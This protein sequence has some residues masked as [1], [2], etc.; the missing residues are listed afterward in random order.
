MMA[1][2]TEDSPVE[3]QSGEPTETAEACEACEPVEA[4]EPCV[5]E[6]V[7]EPVETIEDIDIEIELAPPPKK[8]G[9]SVVSVIAWLVVVVAVLAGLA[10]AYT[11]FMGKEKE[12][13]S[14]ERQARIE[15]Y[16]NQVRGAARDVA[17]A[18]VLVNQGDIGSALAKLDSASEQ[19][20]RIAGDAATQ[21]DTEYGLRVQARKT[22]LV[23]AAEAIR[24][25]L[26]EVKDFTVA[27]V[28]KAREAMPEV[29][30][31][32]PKEEPAA[33]APPAEAAPPPAATPAPA[34]A[35][36]PAAPEAPP[37]VP[38]PPAVAAPPADATPPAAVQPPANGA[39]PTVAA[40]PAAAAPG[41]A[42]AA[43]PARHRRMFHRAPA[44]PPPTG[45]EG[46][47]GG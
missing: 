45:G 4:C 32:A 15:S 26:G 20:S 10:Y 24:Q 11:F 16:D 31:P 2:Q 22:A 19:L 35:P 42:P 25:K 33:A 18:D 23:D 3:G 9:S 39:A 46:P 29:R 12:R 36:P 7:T 43:P 38:A 14:S 6:E 8:R 5:P 13:V 1:E 28:A 44:G 47:G 37:A 41:V 17:D 30:N 40:P 21:G 27:E 34:V